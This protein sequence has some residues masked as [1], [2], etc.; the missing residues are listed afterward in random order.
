MKQE[1]VDI[2]KELGGNTERIKG[3]SLSEDLLSIT[4][5]TVLY[6]DQFD[7]GDGLRFCGLDDFYNSNK[8][9]Y[10]TDEALFFT[11]MLEKYF[12]KTEQGL[13]QKFWRGEL[14]TP[15]NKGTKDFAE[16]NDLF[17]DNSEYGTDLSEI[18]KITND[19]TPDFLLLFYSYGYPD[20]YY[21]C[22]SD[23]NP[24]NPTVF[25]T[26]HEEFFRNIEIEGTL[27]D[28]MK[29]FITKKR[30]LEIAKNDIRGM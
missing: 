30:F 2:F 4:F 13:G 23:P 17:M 19:P 24:E 1:I 14:F 9:L 11:K 10:H 28:F 15:L 3:K 5:D 26:D 25:G 16:W 6:A 7:E 12:C 18:R 21:I 20:H 29:K 8:E 22:L 27:E